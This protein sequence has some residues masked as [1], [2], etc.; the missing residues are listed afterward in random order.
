MMLYPFDGRFSF[1]LRQ[2]RTNLCELVKGGHDVMPF[3]VIQRLGMLDG[4]IIEHPAELPRKRDGEILVGLGRQLRKDLSSSTSE[5]D[6]CESLTGRCTRFTE[7]HAERALH[8]LESA[9]E[10]GK[11]APAQLMTAEHFRQRVQL[12]RVV[13]EGR[14]GKS[15]SPAAGL[16]DTRREL[17]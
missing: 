3:P 2:V 12:L 9:L 8:H 4:E 5:R 11:R 16:P 7:G 13:Q 10:G 14:P 6:A 15:D 17:S 1:E